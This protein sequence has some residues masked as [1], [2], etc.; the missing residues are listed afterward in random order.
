MDGV[1]H[2]GAEAGARWNPAAVPLDAVTAALAL[3]LGAVQAAV[4]AS[5]GDFVLVD[6]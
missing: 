6:E 4:G 3:L 2:G 5:R 1:T